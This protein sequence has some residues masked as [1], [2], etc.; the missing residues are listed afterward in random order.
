MYCRILEGKLLPNRGAEAVEIVKQQADK[1]KEARGFQF[2]QALQSDDDFI[3]ISSW[4]SEKDLR[5]Y[6]ESDIAHGVLS[7]LSPLLVGD[8]TVRTF[9]MKLVVQGEEGLFSRDEGGEG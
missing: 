1:V 9:Q 6:A 3:V 5:A 7:R 8:P 4:R 2:A